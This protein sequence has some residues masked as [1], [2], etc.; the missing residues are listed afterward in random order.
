MP[1]NISIQD[2]D[3]LG[4]EKKNLNKTLLLPTLNRYRIRRFSNVYNST[5]CRYSCLLRLNDSLVTWR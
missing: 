2:K 1:E 4:K 3:N 5:V